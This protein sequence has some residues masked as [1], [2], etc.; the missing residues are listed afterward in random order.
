MNDGRFLSLNPPI[1]KASTVVFD[2]TSQLEKL[3]N[4]NQAA[5]DIGGDRTVSLYGTHGTPTHCALCDEILR[6]EGGAGVALS[7]SGLAAI[8]VALFSVIKGGDHILIT[9]NAYGPVRNIAQRILPRMGVQF[10]FYDPLIGKNIS[11]LFRANTRSIWIESS[12]APP[13]HTCH[14]VGGTQRPR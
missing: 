12:W 7:S 6:R 10:D 13:G 4:L 9:D 3:K 1:H 2:S 8:T 11:Q 5:A 14:R